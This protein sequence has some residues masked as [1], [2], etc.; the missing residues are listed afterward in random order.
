MIGERIVTPGAIVQ[1]IF[2]LRVTPPTIVLPDHPQT[3]E[4]TPEERKKE[5]REE[6]EKEIAFLNDGKSEADALLPGLTTVGYAH[7]PHWPAV[8]LSAGNGDLRLTGWA[9]FPEPETYLVGDDWR[10]EDE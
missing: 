9:E 7:A 10:P 8:C 2:K 4:P 5:V 3:P 6:D 1:T